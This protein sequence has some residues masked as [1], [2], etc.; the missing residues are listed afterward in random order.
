MA[1]DPDSARL[2]QIH[3]AGRLHLQPELHGTGARQLSG[4]RGATRQAVPPALRPDR[5]CRPRRPLHST[6]RGH[7]DLP[8][9]R[10]QP[11]RRPHPA[12]VPGDDRRHAAH[13]LLPEGQ[14]RQTEVLPLVQ[15]QPGQD[16]E[17]A[18]AAADVRDLR[19]FAADRGG[20]SARRQG[21]P[22]RPALVGPH[23]GFPHGDPRPGQGPDR[24]ER[25][26]RP[27]RIE[28]RL[29]RQAATRRR[30]SR[31]P[32]GRRGRL[33]QDLPARPA[34]PDRQSGA[35][36]SDP[37]GRRRPSRRR[38][39]LP[40]GGRRQ[41]HR[42]LLR[43]RQ[44]RRRRVRVLAQRRLRLR[45]I[46]RL[47]PQ[48]DGHHRPW[49]VGVGQAPLPR[50]GRRYPGR[51]LHRRRHRR[52]V[53]RRLRQRHA[54]VAAHP[55]AGGLRPPPHLH[56]PGSRF[57]PQ[58]GRT[59]APVR[60]APVELGRLRQVADLAGRRCLVAGS[61]VD[62]GARAC[63]RGSRHQRRQAGAQRTDPPIADGPGRP[64]L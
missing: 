38:R 45:W 40:G 46:G 15:A 33:L 12:P 24:Q 63:T 39:S 50:T 53:R 16:S 8:R 44:R 7:A 5:G 4:L 34:R 60:A 27:G 58:L 1:G 18:R 47:R 17:S 25:G 23:G 41:G 37:A 26:D 52:H 57:R 35:R 9:H 64:R 32:A 6:A 19:L 54:A 59:Q 43:H 42:D 10:R 14:R 2:C 62:Q 49:R 51:G 11:R 31:I 29:R 21:R 20:P 13:Q 22:R 30:R 48:E 55:A 3:E 36:R 28:G 56:R 61:E